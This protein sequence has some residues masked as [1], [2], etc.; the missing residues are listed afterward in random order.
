MCATDSFFEALKS[1]HYSTEWSALLFIDA[2][3]ESLKAVMFNN[4]N[5]RTSIPFVHTMYTI[6]KSTIQN[7]HNPK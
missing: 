5:E 6:P 4:G 1:V 2:S 3:K 7:E